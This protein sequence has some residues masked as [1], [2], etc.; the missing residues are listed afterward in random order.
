MPKLFLQVYFTL[1][2]GRCYFKVELRPKGDRSSSTIRAQLSCGDSALLTHV[3]P[4]RILRFGSGNI[5]A[6]L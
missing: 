2:Q 6:L 3:A 1:H 5:Q 4:N